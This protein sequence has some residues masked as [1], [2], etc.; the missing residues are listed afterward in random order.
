M[1]WGVAQRMNAGDAPE[2]LQR[3]KIIQLDLNSLIASASERNVEELVARAMKELESAGNVIL[4]IDEMQELMPAK[5]E[6]S[7]QSV[8][9]IILPYL[10][11]S[12]FPVIGTV[13]YSDYKRYFYNNESLRQLFTNI[14]I[15]E[16]SAFSAMEILETKIDVLEDNFNLY[17]TF[18]AL[19]SAVE[20]A[21]RYNRDRKLPSSAVQ[22]IESACSWAQENEIN[23]LTDE[24]ISK[25]IS[26]QKKVPVSEIT[27]EEST[28]LLNLEE[29][30][31]KKVI[32]QDEAVKKIAET[33]RRAR[34]DIRNPSEKPIG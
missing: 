17:I 12:K 24:H 26:L 4:F 32:G 14:E 9:S 30:L 15:E 25:V 3:K 23:V 29:D 28:K 11:N 27:A 33:L 34:T 19:E 5:A 7:G 6:G 8:S 31:K 21:K 10:M 20:L 22:L 13:N 18:P 2:Q 1:V 16:M